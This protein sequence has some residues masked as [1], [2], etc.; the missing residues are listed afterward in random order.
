M[1]LVHPSK[2]NDRKEATVWEQRLLIDELRKHYPFAVD[3]KTAT[4]YNLNL[5]YNN[6]EISILLKKLVRERD[7]LAAQKQA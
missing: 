2:F 4:E 1:N 6:N 5:L 7:A 3:D